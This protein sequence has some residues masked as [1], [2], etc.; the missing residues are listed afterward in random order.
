L[1]AVSIYYP[2]NSVLF[3]FNNLFIDLM[4]KPQQT[5]LLFG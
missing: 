1:F 3:N 4:P 5:N 2:K